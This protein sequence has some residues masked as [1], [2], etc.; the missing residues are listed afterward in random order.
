M[1]MKSKYLKF[2]LL[3]I[4]TFYSFTGCKQ[5][6]SIESN[7]TGEI[8]YPASTPNKNA[9][10]SYPAPENEPIIAPVF[11]PHPSLGIVYGR[12]LHNGEPVVGYSVYLADLVANDQGEERVA[13]LK[14]SSSPQAVLDSEGYFVFNKVQPDRYALMFSDGISSYLLLKPE[15][16]IQEA[17]LI[18]VNAGQF[19]DLGVLD[20]SDFPLD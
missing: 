13:S 20:Y 19:T 5:V 6:P 10:Q 17:I 3:T 18:E 11:T 12:L 9:D 2:I 15:Q 14:I 4:I 8:G 7:H 1:S 16:D